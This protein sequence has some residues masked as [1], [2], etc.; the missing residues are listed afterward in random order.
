M[1]SYKI[2]LT[3]KA[4]DILDK[5]D[6]PI[7]KRILNFLY[8]RVM[9]HEDPKQL[10][11]PLKGKLSDYWRFRV[12]NYRIICKIKDDQPLIIVITINHR[13]DVYRLN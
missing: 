3:T 6:K 2:E 7:A 9:K 12:G 10:A 11:K 4:K 13:K 8:N 1:I 5:L